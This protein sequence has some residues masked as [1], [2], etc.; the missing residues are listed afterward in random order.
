[1]YFVINQLGIPF[2]KDSTHVLA[3]LITSPIEA[4]YY[5]AT[6]MGLRNDFVQMMLGVY[7]C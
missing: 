5:S 2:R 6:G 7:G 4:E 3:E 1:M